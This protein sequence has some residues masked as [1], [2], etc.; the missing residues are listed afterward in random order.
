M[1]SI[2]NPPPDLSCP[3]EISQ[4][5]SSDG[6]SDKALKEVDLFKSGLDDD[7]DDD[8]DDENNNPLPKFSIR[9]YVFGARNKDIKT[10]WPFSLENLQLC[11]EH[12]V[13]DLLPPFQSID[14]VRNQF[15]KR[16]AA[17]TSL[18]DKENKSKSDGETS[19][20]S[21]EFVS[22]SL[23]FAGENQKLNNQSYSKINSIPTNIS[24]E[25]SGVETTGPLTSQ[26]S[27]NTNQ[28]PV[29]KCRLIVK[30][31]TRADLSSNEDITAATNC[32]TFPEPMASKVCPVCK[33]FSSSSNTT[34]NAH[35]D[36]CLS[37]E[38]TITWTPNS[39]VTKHRIKPRKTR[40]MVDIYATAPHCTL[41]DLDR[42]N[43]T[44]WAMNSSLPNQETAKGVELEK[45]RVLSPVN[46]NDNGN[47][48]AVY[49]DANGRKL[50]I[51][52]K[53]NDTFSS[54]PED[55]GPQKPFTGRVR[56]LLSTYK[57][58][59]HHSQKHKKYL[60]LAQSKKFCSSKLQ[61]TSEIRRDVVMNFASEESREKGESMS[62]WPFKAQER[63]KCNDLGT[64]TKWACSKRTGLVKRW[65]LKEGLRHLRCNYR[66]DLQVES[67]QSSLGD[68][69]QKTRNSS[70]GSLSSPESSKRMENSSFEA[71]VNEFNEQPPVRKRLGFSA[72]GS[73]ISGKMERVLESPKHNG[74]WLRKDNTSVDGS[75]K[76]FGKKQVE[77]NTSIVKNSSHDVCSNLSRSHHSFSPKATKFSSSRKRLLSVNQSSVLET[78]YKLNQK[79]SARKRSKVHCVA[80]FHKE[81]VPL[82]S[83]VFEKHDSRENVENQSRIEESTATVSRGCVFKI[84]RKRR[85][86]CISE[87]ERSTGL[88]SALEFHSQDL[89]D[90]VDSSARID[91]DLEETFDDI[92]SG[93]KKIQTH[94]EDIIMSLSKGT[95]FSNTLVGSLQSNV[96]KSGDEQE[97]FCLDEVC[98]G[99]ID[100]STYMGTE[101]DYKD[102][103]GNYF[104]EV[105]PIPIPG[106]PGSFLPSPRAG[107]MG[108][109]DL[110]GN[111]SL[112]TSR[113]QSFEDHHHDLVDR[114]SSDSPI[115]A[116]STV[117]NSTIARSDSKSSEILSV[118]Q[119]IAHDEIPQAAA[120]QA[121]RIN[122]EE[123][124]DMI[125]V[126]EKG[127]T[128]FRN[129]QPCC[130]SSREGTSLGV[131]SNYQESQL[132]R[133]RNCDSNRRSNSLNSNPEVKSL[134]DFPSSG[135]GKV[136]PLVMKLAAGPI[137]A[138]VTLTS[139]VHGD[140]DSASPSTSN[141]VLR[142]MGKNLM[143]VNKDDN[144]S[145]QLNPQFSTLHQHSLISCQSQ[146]NMGFESKFPD[147][148]GSHVTSKPPQTPSPS[149]MFSSRNMGGFF[150]TTFEPHE[151]KVRFNSPAD[152]DRSRN[153]PHEYKVRFNLPNDQENSRNRPYTPPLAYNTNKVV[154]NANSNINPMKEIIIIDDS[155]D[156]ETVSA[157]ISLP[158]AANY[159]PSH[160][161]ASPI[162][163]NCTSEG[164]SVL[165]PSSSM[166][167]S[168]TG[169]LGSSLYYSP[170]F[171]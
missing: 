40:L 124:V 66:Q 48:G 5:N 122:L 167:S 63:I 138:D 18:I 168:L 12:G 137:S 51:L 148:F 152:Q 22:G 2:E 81:A 20:P 131:S 52:S 39:G 49:I 132:L 36:Q 121:D 61:R 105:D 145:Q 45:Q 46:F 47:E 142:L 161:N 158:I 93:R 65:N 55:H 26:N 35:I 58:T 170:S 60:K 88:K 143:V 103:Q 159:N 95:D 113:V 108:S 115:S 44:N 67:D 75:F 8:D 156:G 87:D 169:Q 94:R 74:K 37:M 99:V 134:G 43:G 15:I 151:Y 72:L 10:N 157:D 162:K 69:Y 23:D 126:P 98:N 163:W 73:R 104:T 33:T 118:G 78:K 107:D 101:M 76:D 70:E 89:G 11:L 140:Y 164:S 160:A 129:D 41:E 71:P 128:S 144:A 136:G 34:L 153:E 53:F 85:V 57:K 38:S 6:A 154:T 97:M 102:G 114:D 14:Y 147:S 31:G 110:Q 111:S 19:G 28:S 149:G 59:K 50:R 4:L 117:S 3:L 109:E 106:P 165:P 146:R 30:V 9:D 56:K 84:R 125:V 64:I 21:D 77:I 133:R 141:S 13:K 29:K 91:S 100:Q 123:R 16:C 7:D 127:P 96:F 32:A 120:I 25:D 42:R 116:M 68:S 27:E 119:H 17:E 90:N 135:S 1:L 24:L 166:A 171:S 79:F 62:T 83:D 54:V 155:P 130:C 80:N 112:T 139:P 86:F 92:E 82:P 150:T